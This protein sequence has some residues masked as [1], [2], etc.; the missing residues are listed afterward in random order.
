LDNLIALDGSHYAD[1]PVE[2]ERAAERAESLA[3]GDRLAVRGA[4]VVIH[5]STIFPA[6]ATREVLLF[7][8]RQGFNSAPE[9]R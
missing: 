8:E 7:L 9:N 5:T 3:D 2:E 6:E 4:D 1:L